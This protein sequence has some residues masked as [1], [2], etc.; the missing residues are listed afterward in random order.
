MILQTQ[1]M[2]SHD[3]SNFLQTGPFQHDFNNITSSNLILQFSSNRPFFPNLFLQHY[4]LECLDMMSKP[5]CSECPKRPNQNIQTS[6]PDAPN[7]T[8]WIPSASYD[9]LHQLGGAAS[10]GRASGDRLRSAGLSTAAIQVPNAFYLIWATFII[11][12]FDSHFESH[13][14]VN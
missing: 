14:V 4:A 3:S 8:S 2:V 12:S 9:L 13:V 10:D 7:R 1:F 11:F 6:C 5:K